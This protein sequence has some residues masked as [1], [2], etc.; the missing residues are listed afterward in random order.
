M[1]DVYS[2]YATYENTPA[3]ASA[4]FYYVNIDGGISLGNDGSTTVGPYRWIIRKTSKY[5]ETISYVRE[6]HFF[7]GEDDDPTSMNNGQWTM[8][9]EESATWFDLNGRRLASKPTQKGIYIHNGR[10]EVVR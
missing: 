10:K 7:D 9:N 8:N 1:E 4:P 3:T 6:M 2:F 5:G